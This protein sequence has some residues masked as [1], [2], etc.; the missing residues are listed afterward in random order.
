LSWITFKKRH[1]L[2]GMKIEVRTPDMV[3]YRYFGK[4]TRVSTLGNGWTGFDTDKFT[5]CAARHDYAW[6]EKKKGKR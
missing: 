3:A 5:G 4:V 2:L 6:R 1:P